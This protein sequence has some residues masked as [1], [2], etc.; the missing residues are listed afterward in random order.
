MSEDSSNKK[1]KGFKAAKEKAEQ[2]IG[3]EEKLIKLL[4]DGQKKAKEKQE[5]LKSVWNDFQALFRLIKAWWKKEYTSVPW[6]T[7]LYAIAAVFYFVNPFDVVPDFIP[8]L[9]LLDDITL[10]TF[11]INSLKKD[12]EAFLNWESGKAKEGSETT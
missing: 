8:A 2:I 1:P 9:G 5:K 6:K 12:I 3:N 4:N 10:I 11:V 7:I